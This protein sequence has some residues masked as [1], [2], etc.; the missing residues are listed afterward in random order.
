MF[1]AGS[2]RRECCFFPHE[3]EPHANRTAKVRSN[4]A[5]LTGVNQSEDT[6]FRVMLP[7]TPGKSGSI[8]HP[9]IV[10]TTTLLIG[11]VDHNGKGNLVVRCE[12]DSLSR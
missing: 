10:F 4:T 11:G 6:R 9:T 3:E 1:R 2:V 8:A 7:R 5:I 12:A